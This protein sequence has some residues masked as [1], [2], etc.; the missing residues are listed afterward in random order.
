M[1][2]ASPGFLLFRSRLLFDAKA[3]N[4]A[5]LELMRCNAHTY[6]LELNLNYVLE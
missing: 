6:L 3:E 4:E 5:F 1:E 2:F